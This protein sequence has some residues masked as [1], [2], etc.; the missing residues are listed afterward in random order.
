MKFLYK[1]PQKKF[2]YDDLLK[3]NAKRSREEHEYQILDTGVFD[4]DRYWDIIIETA[5]EDDN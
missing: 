4:E 1:Y 3:E 5:K 2:P